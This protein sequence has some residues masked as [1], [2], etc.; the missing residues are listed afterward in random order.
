[1]EERRGGE[2]ETFVEKETDGVEIAMNTRLSLG[3]NERSVV[4]GG[5]GWWRVV[6]GGGDQTDLHE[7]GVVVGR[8]LFEDRWRVGGEEAQHLLGHR[9]V[10]RP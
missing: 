7:R 2:R 6:A 5:G 1:M 4:A 10:E 3:M 9:R 8:L